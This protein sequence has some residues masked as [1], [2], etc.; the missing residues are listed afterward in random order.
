MSSNA[1]QAG[2]QGKHELSFACLP[3]IP[4]WTWLEWLTTFCTTY[5]ILAPAIGILS[6]TFFPDEIMLS[7]FLLPTGVHVEQ[8]STVAATVLYSLTTVVFCTVI[9]VVLHIL[10]SFSEYVCIASDNVGPGATN[11]TLRVRL[12]SLA[13][14]TA[15]P[16]P[17]VCYTTGPYHTWRSC[18]QHSTLPRARCRTTTEMRLPT[19]LTALAS[20]RKRTGLPAT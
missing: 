15:A 6:L 11:S 14:L 4:T 5:M 12:A 18:L 3:S 19:Q 10:W 8:Y 2:Q 1:L 7:M 13:A 17:C 16:H 9:V 20:S